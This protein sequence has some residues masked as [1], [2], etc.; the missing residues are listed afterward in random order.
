MATKRRRQ[1]K[2]ARGRKGTAG[3]RP[4]RPRRTSKRAGSRSGAREARREEFPRLVA[5]EPHTET[6]VSEW[7]E[8][9]TAGES[10][11]GGGGVPG[12]ARQAAESSASAAAEGIRRTEAAEAELQR[13]REEMER[14]RQANGEERIPALSAIGIEL[15]IGA[16]RLA[17]TIATAPLRIGLAFLRPREE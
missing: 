13:R 10:P 12:F 5:A 9:G 6:R 1:G 4:A 14:A 17:R 16:M 15:A 3:Q 2:R 7:L 11:P 8:H